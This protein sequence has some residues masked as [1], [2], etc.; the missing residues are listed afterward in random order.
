VK[1]CNLYGDRFYYIPGTN[2]ASSSADMSGFN[3]V[4]D[5]TTNGIAGGG[6]GWERSLPAGGV[7]KAARFMWMNCLAHQQNLDAGLALTLG[8]SAARFNSSQYGTAWAPGAVF[9]SR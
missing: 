8:R 3:A 1:I 9:T 4:S 6:S 2:T 5:T 7:G